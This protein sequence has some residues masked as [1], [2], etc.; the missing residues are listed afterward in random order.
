VKFKKEYLILIVMLLSLGCGFSVRVPAPVPISEDDFLRYHA[1]GKEVVIF[2]DEEFT[3]NSVEYF[4]S[5]GM[6][7][8]DATNLDDAVSLAGDSFVEFHCVRE[9]GDTMVVHASIPQKIYLN[10][11][12]PITECNRGVIF[13]GFATEENPHIIA[14]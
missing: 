14:Y 9:S 6:I 11:V 8:S 1:R 5:I 3:A 10:G 12:E 13:I 4:E 7:V 2:G